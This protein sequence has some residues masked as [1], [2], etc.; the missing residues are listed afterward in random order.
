MY[1]KLLLQF[2]KTLLLFLHRCSI[3]ATWSWHSFSHHLCISAATIT[4]MNCFSWI[5]KVLHFEN[6]LFFTI[7]TLFLFSFHYFF[8]RVFVIDESIF[9]NLFTFLIQLLGLFEAWVR[10]SGLDNKIRDVAEFLFIFFGWISK[11]I[12]YFVENLEQ[13]ITSK[14][15]LIKILI[16][17][18]PTP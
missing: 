18:R 14:L 11:W 7:F 13:L 2:L 4:W 1:Q 16:F 12:C 15:V 9:K 6:R 17:E 5:E 10:S 3:L 8:D